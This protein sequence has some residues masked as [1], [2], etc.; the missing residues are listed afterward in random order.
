MLYATYE[1]A[2]YCVAYL[3]LPQQFKI[4]VY[5]IQNVNTIRSRFKE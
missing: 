3:H 5:F 4:D 1:I 2:M